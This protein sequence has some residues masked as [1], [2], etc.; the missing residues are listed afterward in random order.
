MYQPRHSKLRLAA[1]QRPALFLI[2]VLATGFA[3]IT[4]SSLA[5]GV[6]KY[7]DSNGTVVFSDLPP[8]NQQAFEEVKLPYYP[9]V[10]PEERRQTMQEIRETSDRLRADRLER[11][12]ARETEEEPKA[13]NRKVRVESEP[14]DYPYW[15]RNQRD[16]DRYPRNR[17]R[18]S[19][20]PTT[21]ETG[22]ERLRRN[23]RSPLNVPRQ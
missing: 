19:T 5:A 14:R 22:E 20:E 21:P 9:P 10:N 6:Y 23:L 4:E 2:T 18:E 11:E 17:G 12:A 15:Y 16:R 7:V 8:G 3:G 1:T 13:V